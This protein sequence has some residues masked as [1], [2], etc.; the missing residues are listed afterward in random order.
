MKKALFIYLFIIATVTACTQSRKPDLFP[1]LD[2]VD[3]YLIIIT[4]E[5][6]AGGEVANASATAPE[7]APRSGV[8]ILNNTT[9]LFEYLDIGTNNL[10]GH[11]G[12]TNNATHGWELGL[13]NEVDSGMFSPKTR[14]HL[15]KTGQGGSKI[16]DWA[17]GGSYSNTF[18]SRVAAGLVELND[19]SLTYKPIIWLT[20]GINDITAATN[21]ETFISAT[22]AHIA[23]MRT[24]VGADTPVLYCLLMSEY[25]SFNP[26]IKRI[27]DETQY[28]YPVYS[29]PA[30]T[31]DV[32]HWDYAGMKLIAAR[33]A[34]Y[35]RTILK[36]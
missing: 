19:S 16:V 13:A 12:L 9:M 31:Q 33:M 17:D 11:F 4:G 32:N 10:I 14:I 21:H 1:P 22:K 18:E 27:C 26:V 6:N 24:A 5:S 36:Q 29:E 20:L 2:T 34:W 28:V 25:E 15:I 3:T 23:N 35:T 30:T 8:K 7:L